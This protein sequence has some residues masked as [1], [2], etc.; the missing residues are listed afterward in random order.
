MSIRFS[1]VVQATLLLVVLI[2]KCQCYVFHRTHDY[3]E[4]R[5]L[6]LADPLSKNFTGDYDTIT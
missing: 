3:L 6:N 2:W 5:A 1:W 4:A